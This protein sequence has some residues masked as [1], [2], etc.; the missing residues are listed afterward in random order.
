LYR[1]DP[2]SARGHRPVPVRIAASR[3]WDEPFLVEKG[4]FAVL[5]ANATDGTGAFQLPN[6][7]PDGDGITSYS[8]F[9]RALG[10]P[11]GSSTTTT[12]AT[13]PSTGEI[14]CST[15]S[16]VLVRGTGGSKFTNVSKQ[17]LF[18]VADIDGDGNLD[19]V[20]PVRRS[21][22]G[23]LLAV[24]QQRP[25]PRPAQVLRGRDQREL[26]ARAPDGHRTWARLTSRRS[27]AP[28]SCG[29]R[30]SVDP[31]PAWRN[32]AVLDI[33]GI[34]TTREDHTGW[35]DELCNEARWPVHGLGIPR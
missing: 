27:S 23:L 31:D 25:P 14:V 8:V 11:G 24:R 28:T 18:V 34:V 29:P 21:P 16:S 33:I 5:D 3:A 9:S 2:D 6:P 35:G 22:A 30:S 15:L 12:C 32:A 1:S 19:R 7:D 26:T 20:P 17:L 4:D 10:T 13:D